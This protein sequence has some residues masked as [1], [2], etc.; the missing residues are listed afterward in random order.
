M[1]YT[2]SEQPFPYPLFVLLPCV[3]S[4]FLPREWRATSVTQIH[5]LINAVLLDSRNTIW[6]TWHLQLETFVHSLFYNNCLISRS[7][8]GSF[9]SSIRLQTDKIENYDLH[10]LHYAIELLVRI[11]LSETLYIPWVL[12]VLILVI[13]KDCPHL[14]LS[15]YWRSIAS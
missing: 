5:N 13:V 11:R 3:W 9:L 10:T 7:L 2:F 6:T 14:H 15:S 4:T 1:H 8:I 12:P